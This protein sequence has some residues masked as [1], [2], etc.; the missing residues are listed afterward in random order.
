[1][2]SSR[3][4]QHSALRILVCAVALGVALPLLAKGDLTS[5]RQEKTGQSSPSGHGKTG[6]SEIPVCGADPS[7]ADGKIGG[8]LLELDGKNGLQFKC[9]DNETLGPPEEQANSVPKQ[10]VNVYEYNGNG[11]CK[12]EGHVKTLDSIV[13]GATLT[14]ST[15]ASGEERP[16]QVRKVGQPVYTLNYSKDPDGEQLLCYTCNKPSGLSSALQSNP[17]ATPCVVRIKV[18]GKAHPPT[19][20][21]STTPPSSTVS[22]STLPTSTSG[23]SAIAVGVT[24]VAATFLGVVLCF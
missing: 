24:A 15:E 14:Q 6:S 1:M 23:D 21:T 4:R 12:I 9:A 18:P 3:L 2:G 22:S 7:G 10:F 17:D 8:K 16:A 5:G 11:T 19:P 20:N 13:P